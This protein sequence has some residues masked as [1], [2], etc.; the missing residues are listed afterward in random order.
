[1]HK[2]IGHWRMQPPQHDKQHTHLVK[3]DHEQPA[4]TDPQK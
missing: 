2:Q 1:M 3:P 4:N